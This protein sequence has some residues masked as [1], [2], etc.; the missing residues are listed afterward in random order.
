MNNETLNWLMKLIR[1][2]KLI[3]FYKGAK[4]RR[5]RIQ[6]L[7]RDNYECQRC[8]Q[9]GKYSPAKNVHHKIEV[10]HRPDLALDLNNT[11]S[12]CIR[13]HNKEH[14]RYQ[15]KN[16]FKRKPFQNFNPEERW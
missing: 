2:D 12:V 8:K 5:L 13:C 1:E 3:Y 4:W 9:L 15:G 14:D 10:K 11:E 16:R 6:A 7:E